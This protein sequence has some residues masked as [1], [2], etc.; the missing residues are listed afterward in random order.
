MAKDFLKGYFVVLDNDEGIVCM[1]AIGSLG[2]R[3][4]YKVEGAADYH[5]DNIYD[6]D[7]D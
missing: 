3:W 4:I 7:T 5:I 2:Q 1:L 6:H